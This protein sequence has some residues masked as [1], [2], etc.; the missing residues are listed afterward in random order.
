MESNIEHRDILNFGKQ[1]QRIIEL[2]HT[3]PL[4][5]H[6]L[7]SWRMGMVTFE[8]AMI[9]C[10]ILQASEIEAKNALLIKYRMNCPPAPIVYKR[11]ASECNG[12]WPTGDTF[13]DENYLY[14]I[15]ATAC[16]DT[17][18]LIQCECPCLSCGEHPDDCQCCDECGQDVC[19]CDHM[20]SE[21]AG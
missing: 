14:D 2:S 5:N 1:R 15:G 13:R 10:V 8:Q 7:S 9:E 16:C 6:I 11:P 19:G 20:P 18:G 17:C 4:V 3:N 21:P 12:D